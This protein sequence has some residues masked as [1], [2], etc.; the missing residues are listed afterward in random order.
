[1]RFLFC[2]WAVLDALRHNEYFAWTKGDI[3]ISHLYGDPS[4]EYKKEVV[5]FVVLVPDE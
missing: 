4:L 2:D 3:A 5:R 1:V